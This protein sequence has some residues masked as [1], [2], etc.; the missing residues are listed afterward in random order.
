MERIRPVRI[1]AAIAALAVVISLVPAPPA[2]AEMSLQAI[3]TFT[4]RGSG[5]GHGIGMSQYGAQ[6]A[7]LAGKD[8]RWIIGHYYSDTTVGTASTP[9]VQVNID[10]AYRD[11]NY[12]GRP[13]WTIRAVGSPLNVWRTKSFDPTITLAADTFY[14]FT[15]DGTTVTIRDAAGAVKGQF[16]WDVWVAPADSAK[17]L[18]EVKDKS[19]STDGAYHPLTA[20]GLPTNGY[21]N[22]RYR[23]KIWLERKGTRLAA[24]NQLQM[25]HYLYGVVPRESPASWHLDALKAQAVAARSYGFADIAGGRILKCTTYSQVYKGHSRLS[26]GVVVAH[27]AASTNQAVDETNNEVVKTSSGAVATTYFFSQSG[28]HTANNEDVWVSGSPLSYTRGV[29]DPYE[30]LADP[31]YSPWPADKEKTYSG[32]QLSEKLQGIS[33]VPPVSAFVTGI[34][35][36][37][38]ESG[39]AK[40]VNFT[41]ANGATARV[42]GDTVRSRLGLLSTLFYTIVFPMERIY[43]NTRYDTAAKVSTNAFPSTAPA[44]V[45]ASGEDYADALTGSALAGAADGALLLSASRALPEATRR[46]LVRLAPTTV[47]IMGGTSALSAEVE[48]AVKAAVPGAAVRRLQGANRYQTARMAADIVA[49]L[50]GAEKAIVASGT[51][52][53][54]A[55]AASALAYAKAYPILLTRADVLDAEAAG[56]LAAERPGTTLLVGGTSVLSPSIEQ[57]VKGATS[58]TVHRDGGYDR[59]ETAAKVAQRCLDQEAFT[60]DEVYLAAGESYADALTGGTIAGLRGRTLLLTR[61][62]VCPANTATFLRAHRDTLELLWLLGGEAA[63]SSEGQAALDAV[64]AR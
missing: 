37:R 51:G 52:W 14:T 59:Y 1:V 34:S 21:Y 31:P 50:G 49:G 17:G 22:V 46:E 39:H 25:Q 8:Y 40:Y 38:T 20:E 41:F 3:P 19:T 11:S 12:P 47:Y 61:A 36:E 29:P 26:Q 30:Q 58:G 23:G 42:S 64:V 56:F 2:S 45:L 10:C 35:I 15:T 28:G 16:A 60:A 7:A 33:G 9:E 13:S 27:E 63:I 6:G 48:R 32:L 54:D 4:F 53:A 5:Y 43:G 55:A 24:V 57:A 62:D 18:L 44:V